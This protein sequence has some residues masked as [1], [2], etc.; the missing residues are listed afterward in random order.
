MWQYITYDQSLRL[1]IKP[2][3]KNSE[4]KLFESGTGNAVRI[5][6]LAGM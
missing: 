5:K 2:S 6:S 4:I 1:I 3:V